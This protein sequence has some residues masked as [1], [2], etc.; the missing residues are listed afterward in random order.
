M[1]RTAEQSHKTSTLGPTAAQRA[2]GDL[3]REHPAD[4][5]AFKATARQYAARCGKCGATRTDRQIGMEDRADCL[6]WATGKR[7][8][9]CFVCHLVEVF[10]ELRRVLRDDGTLWLN[11]GDS[12]GDRGN[13]AGVP[14]RAAL[15]L[16]ADGWVLRSD[17]P[18]VKRSAMP[19]SADNRPCKSLEYVFMLTKGSRHYF[20]MDAVRLSSTTPTGAGGACFGRVLNGDAA[21]EAGSSN[22]RYDRPDYGD[23][24]FRNN[25]LWF[26]SINS[27]HGAVG[28][29]DELVGLDVT[30]KGY[31]GAHFAVFGPELITPLI[32]A[33]TSDCGA[34]AECGAPY[35]RIP[36]NEVV[37]R[38]SAEK[39]MYASAPEMT[40]TDH[41]NVGANSLR[42]GMR[43]LARSTVGWRK[44]CGCQATNVMPCV[45]LDPF[46]GS[47]TTVATALKL[48]RAGVGIDL[49]E[50][51]TNKNAVPRVVE[52]AVNDKVLAHVL[53]P[54]PP[55]IPVR[56]R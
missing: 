11:L 4:N 52:T 1:E 5:A 21:T 35:E 34:C 39:G 10:G 8:G 13:L 7:C 16:Q 43:T 31:K 42:A 28:V 56:L 6:G 32:M 9:E 51:Y 25:D 47:G 41:Q 48:G 17:V 36:D 22:R 55:A 45:V 40:G 33:S 24:S 54:D 29:G 27:P 50:D 19:E 49:S 12:Y 38:R 23:R 15:A 30:A 14:W 46:S 53:P 20:D 26:A 44:T 2:A 18:W 3:S 37:G